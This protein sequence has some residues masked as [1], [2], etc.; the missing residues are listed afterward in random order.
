M[1][2]KKNIAISETGFVFDPTTGDSFSLNAVGLEILQLFRAGNSQEKI[3][4]QI[5]DKY[6]VEVS[7]FEHYY[8]DFMSM[9]KHHQILEE[10]AED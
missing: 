6:D 7:V 8:F 1:R 10:N 5:T 9:L 4:E 2:I 3:T